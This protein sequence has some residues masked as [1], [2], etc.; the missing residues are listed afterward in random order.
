MSTEEHRLI[1][2]LTNNLEFLGLMMSSGSVSALIEGHLIGTIESTLSWMNTEHINELKKRSAGL[3]SMFLDGECINEWQ[4]HHF[5]N[6]YSINGMV[7]SKPSYIVTKNNLRPPFIKG[8]Q[9]IENY[10][11]L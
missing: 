5:P 6:G 4:L 2:A 11:P 9:F 10:V 3:L 7:F 8:Q 1:I